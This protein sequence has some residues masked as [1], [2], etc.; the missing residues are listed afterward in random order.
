MKIWNFISANLRL[1][2][3]YMM[4]KIGAAVGI[5]PTAAPRFIQPPQILRRSS[6]LNL[7]AIPPR[8]CLSDKFL[9]RTA[10]TF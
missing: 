3:F 9:A 7:V 4:K 5:V 2:A 10:R 6:Y 8:M 1:C